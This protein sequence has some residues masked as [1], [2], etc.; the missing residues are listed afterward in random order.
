MN[1]PKG[2]TTPEVEAWVAAGSPVPDDN[3]EP[4]WPDSPLAPP[5]DDAP[6]MDDDPVQI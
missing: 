5:D 1:N 6:P 3:L 2:M 4:P